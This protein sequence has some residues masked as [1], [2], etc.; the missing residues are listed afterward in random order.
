MLFLISSS[1][2]TKEFKTSYALAKDMSADIC[3]L[4]NAVY[5]SR[6]LDDSSFYVLHDEITLRGIAENEISGR[7]IDYDQLVDLMTGSDK[8]V[9]IF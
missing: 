9:G 1:P 4:Q 6:L 3:L 2:D 5:A 8:V 7:L